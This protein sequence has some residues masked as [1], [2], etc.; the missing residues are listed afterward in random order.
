MARQEVVVRICSCPGRDCK[1]EE[2]R[3]RKKVC[4]DPYESVD[5]RFERICKS[6][7]IGLAIGTR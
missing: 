3:M 4:L 2:E 7:F 1:S 6:I 5:S